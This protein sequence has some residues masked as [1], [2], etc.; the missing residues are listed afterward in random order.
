MR[1]CV[2][3]TNAL[4]AFYVS[5]DKHNEWAENTLTKLQ[6]QSISLYIN[7]TVRQ[8]FFEI[9]RRILIPEGLISMLSSV[10]ISL[11]INISLEIKRVNARSRKAEEEGRVFKMSEAEIKK[12]RK[13]LREIKINQMNGW[14][15]F[16]LDY[17]DP[18]IKAVWSDLL[19][20]L[21]LQFIGTA[22]ILIGDLFNAD[23]KWSEVVGLI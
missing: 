10:D 21:Q 4:I 14:E 12:V 15:Y 6:K 18:Y 19:S 2:I 8:E 22:D 23:L 11:P 1:G 20:K 13:L 9:Y 7:S 17:L 3:D 5:M 16:C